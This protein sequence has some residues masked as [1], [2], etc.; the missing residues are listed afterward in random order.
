MGTKRQKMDFA[1]LRRRETYQEIIN[2]LEN[3][4]EIIKYPDRT[5]KFLRDSPYL[6]QLDGEGQ[7][8]LEE[9]QLN[10]M[11]QQEKDKIL[12]QMGFGGKGGGKG[13][14]RAELQGE[15]DAPDPGDFYNE[16]ADTAG[17]Q[18]PRVFNMAA[19][20]EE[21]EE[22]ANPVAAE[23][24]NDRGMLRNA[25]TGA[26]GL[27]KKAMYYG[28][29]APAGVLWR[30]AVPSFDTLVNGGDAIFNLAN[31]FRNPNDYSHD[32]FQGARHALEGFDPRSR[33]RRGSSSSGDDGYG[34]D[35]RLRRPEPRL[36]QKE[37]VDEEGYPKVPRVLQYHNIERD[38]TARPAKQSIATRANMFLGGRKF[39][40]Q[41]ERVQDRRDDYGRA[42][43]ARF[44]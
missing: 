28:T 3:E 1:G 14:S 38:P 10:A 9:Q 36:I 42:D 35:D 22:P 41:D 16:D 2:Y 4:Q 43:L 12:R 37:E 6:T 7:R 8:T 32:P 19:Q 11:K 21:G 44:R 31:R 17:G 24:E 26:A 34:T 13:K 33:L 23:D 39:R 30:N 25:L 40:S 20:D 27:G 5:A 29:V 18:G 15:L